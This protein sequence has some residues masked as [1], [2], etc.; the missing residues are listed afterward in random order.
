MVALAARR[1]D[2][3]YIAAACAVLGSLLG[4]LIL[5][6][7]A[8]KGGEVVLAK[9]ISRRRGARMHA[10]FQRYGLMT[11]FIPAISPLPLPMKVPVFCAGALKVRWSYFIGVLLV[12]RGIRYFALAYLGRKY[13]HRTFEFLLTHT[14]MLA[15][16]AIGLAVLFGL[17]VWFIDKYEIPEHAGSRSAKPQARS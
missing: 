5:F 12:A 10:W 14:P 16:I 3:A 8:R 2:Q 9:H 13:G 15:A 1:P 7:I 17:A 4:T 11:V 6:A